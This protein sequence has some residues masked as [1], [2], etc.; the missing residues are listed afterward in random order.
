VA[1]L[2]HGAADAQVASAGGLL[3][4]IGGVSS[5]TDYLSTA[6][7]FDPGTDSWSARTSLPSF[8]FQFGAVEGHDGRIYVMGGI[9]NVTTH[10][11]VGGVLEIYDPVTNHWSR[12]ATMPTPRRTPGVVVMSTGLI[13]AV[14]GST[15]GLGSGGASRVA[16][17]DD[18]VSN[19]WAKMPNLIDANDGGGAADVT[20]SSSEEE[21][22][23]VTGAD[24]PEPTDP[25][26]V[27]GDRMADGY[28][29]ANKPTSTSYSPT[30]AF[31]WN[32]TDAVDT[33]TRTGTGNYLVRF[34]FLTTLATNG[35]TVDVNAVGT[36]AAV[37]GVDDWAPVGGAIDAQISCV[38]HSGGAL[39]SE[40]TASFTAPSWGCRRTSPMRGPT[41][42]RRPPTRRPPA[43]STTRPAERS[44]S[45]L[46][47]P[48][49][50]S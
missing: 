36:T 27:P 40:F 50:T 17:E 8:R 9:G 22:V 23:S 39:D 49:S 7:A 47:G 6:E 29:L 28:V 25:I 48:G 11:S 18:P 10:E 33:I 19:T 41:T 12:G 3:N 31:Q 42:L 37:C 43:T 24:T 1:P 38:D 46:S 20:N 5:A 45:T 32:S 26:V 30:A 35:G 21:I 44:P 14:G 16:T 34:P 4:V 2:P 15:G 13:A